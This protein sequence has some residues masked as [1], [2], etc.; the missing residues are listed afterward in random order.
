MLQSVVDRTASS[1]QKSHNSAN[2][3]K[4]FEDINKETEK[5]KEDDKTSITSESAEIPENEANAILLE[6]LDEKAVD[7][8]ESIEFPGDNFQTQNLNVYPTD[9]S[10]GLGVSIAAKDVSVF[11]KT[12]KKPS[13]SLNFFT[14]FTRSKNKLSDI[15]ES[16]SDRKYLIKNITFDIP[17]GNIF[18]II[19]GSGSGKTTLLNTLSQRTSKLN[20]SGEV[21][22]QSKSDNQTTSNIKNINYAYVIQQDILIPSLTCYETLKFSAQLKLS[23][24]YSI[25]E[26]DKLINQI[27]TELGLKDCK[28]TI[29][30]SHFH[31][32]LSGGEKRR[33][34]IA[35]QMLSNPDILF[36]DEPTT[37]LD[38]T[39]AI[40]LIKTLKNLAQ[41]KKKTFVI[42][43]H[44]PRS[45]IFFMF[46]YLCI[47]TR[48]EVMFCDSTRQVVSY[49]NNYL[50]YEIPDTN[51]NVADWLV[52]LTSVD[53]TRGPKIET[54]TLQRIENFKNKWNLYCELSE[55]YHSSTIA[56]IDSK[57]KL[58]SE[59][60]SPL[61]S[62][63]KKSANFRP[64]LFQEIMILTKR[65][66]LLT[67]R[68]PVS[69]ISAILES[70]LLSFIV[71]WI[72]YRPTGSLAGIRSKSASMY[73][74]NGIQ[75]YL[76]LLFESY[77]LC[78]YDIKIF[79]RERFEN[80]VSIPAFIISR[81]VSK[82]ITEDIIVPT[83]FSIVT[84]FML[85]VRC[86]AQSFFIFWAINLYNQQ[87]A[88]AFSML[89][90]SVTR[91][92]PIVNILGN[93]NFTFQSYFSGFFINTA[94]MPVY[95]RWVK[96]LCYVW[97]SY[98]ASVANN[99]LD[100]FG[101][102]PQASQLSDPENSMEC[103][104]YTGK[105]IMENLG[106][107]YAWI[108]LP[109]CV[110]LAFLAIFYSLAA[111]FF[112][113]HKVDI[114]LAKL[115]KGND[116]ETK[117]TNADYKDEVHLK[118]VEEMLNNIDEDDE[119]EVGQDCNIIDA[120]DEG[121]DIQIKDVRLLVTKMNFSIQLILV[122][123][124]DKLITWFLKLGKARYFFAKEENI[125]KLVTQENKQIL[126][127]VT[128]C[129]Q[130]YKINAIM[131]PSGCGKTSLLNLLCGKLKFQSSTCEYF[132]DGQMTF[133]NFQLS[134]KFGDSESKKILQ[135][136]SSYV[137]Q[138]DEHLL[139]L[140]TVYETLL[141]SAML[142]LKSTHTKQQIENKV[143]EIIIKLG[144]KDCKN[145]Y[146]GSE[147]MKGIS[148]GEKRRVSIGIQ[149]LNDPKILFLDEPTSGL[150]SFT[151]LKILK[152]LHDL[153][154]KDKKTIIL[155]IH[156]PRFTIFEKFGTVLLLAKGGNAIFNGTPTEMQRYFPE[157][158]NFKVPKL[159]NFA[160]FVLDLVSI[161]SRTEK[162]EIESKQRLSLLELRW[163]EYRE[164]KNE[165]KDFQVENGSDTEVEARFMELF[166]KFSK[167]RATFKVAFPIIFKRQLLMLTRNKEIP[168]ARIFNSAGIA[169]MST[170]FYT[171]IKKD[172]TGILDTLGLVQQVS[173]AYFAGLLNN[174]TAYP[175]EKNFF[176]EE[177]EDVVY[178]MNT[179]FIVYT[180]LEIPLEFVSGIIY[181][182][183]TVYAIGLPR[184]VGV[185]FVFVYT[186]VMIVNCGE[187]L[188]VFF[189]SMLNHT[190]LAVQIVSVF[191]S[192]AVMMSGLMSIEMPP[193]FRD[194]S[195]IGPVKYAVMSCI[196]IVFQRSKRF[197]CTADSGASEVA[198]D[199][200]VVSCIFNDGNDVLDG[201]NI[202]VDIKLYL[203]LIAVI[204][205]VYRALSF[206]GIYFRLNP[207]TTAI[208]NT[209]K[210]YAK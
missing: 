132:A 11:I 191:L 58:R 101:D 5:L 48:G 164:K 120:Y 189:N 37:G 203:G 177:Y 186:N 99:Y 110:L 6:S 176:Y 66:L 174:M 178:G 172:F 106:Y 81:R 63:T 98:G 125:E 139:P 144:L 46:D 113:I 116:S 121:I 96:Y 156:Q 43:I 1:G 187:S 112:Y 185:F 12:S 102:C 26:Q 175:V 39:A 77:R 108:T 157:V 62:L 192:V 197:T 131:G 50:K 22:Y 103:L 133:N 193:F 169:L 24:K 42:T 91:D 15:E 159:T 9:D 167:K 45:D 79:D 36:L 30:G 23:K 95:V 32:G 25:Q 89:A 117:T 54:Q 148:G 74:V 18:A 180:I 134:S 118:E 68:D 51:V 64:S 60:H 65:D 153:A 72:F 47:L 195:Y 52:D 56:M 142:R 202:R 57:L 16:P 206:L 158:C 31:K 59:K 90:V 3:S 204:T 135:G 35:I 2:N 127:N 14:A 7:T 104:A 155:T 82:L 97:Y 198:S 119:K 85:D 210:R 114:T 78:N 147:F 34:S 138:D 88:C 44:Q 122:K 71:G 70:M 55:E 149:L 146:I 21:I 94:K 188:G 87:L 160:D 196:N 181:G 40:F 136:I 92:Y 80:C 201:Y 33:L 17:A 28:D 162:E 124:F 163:I 19:G 61:T 140:L 208:M 129:F 207:P 145:S 150:D 200:S 141:F 38:A 109:M 126:N 13:S 86:T 166:L 67:S 93:V 168:F 161:D 183:L 29:V 143:D 130:K 84:F 10:C 105:N 4:Q 205:V 73:N 154:T 190:G 41:F 184:E 100:F 173:A 115:R 20:Q 53:N 151:A 194:L 27:I 111:F 128:A 75:G 171:P 182:A 49:F 165:I 69:T 199:G 152:I 179:F 123:P 76:I 8:K 170:L 137:I 107:P 83:I 209:L